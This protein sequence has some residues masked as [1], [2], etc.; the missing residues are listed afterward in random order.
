MVIL[1]D[2]L[3]VTAAE[4]AN[5]EYEYRIINRCLFKKGKIVSKNPPPITEEELNKH[6]QEGWQLCGIATC[7][8]FETISQFSNILDGRL[9]FRRLKSAKQ[10]PSS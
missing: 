4:V 6:G 3:V 7:I 9:I 8:Y 2:T 10:K 5:P 1:D